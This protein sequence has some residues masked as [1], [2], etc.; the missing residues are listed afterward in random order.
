MAGRG[1]RRAYRSAPASLTAGRCATCIRPRGACA[2]CNGVRVIRQDPSAHIRRPNRALISAHVVN[3]RDCHC[4]HGRLRPVL[5]RI[6][7]RPNARPSPAQGHQRS[8]D[9]SVRSGWHAGP[10]CPFSAR[11][12]RATITR[13]VGPTVGAS[14]SRACHVARVSPGPGGTHR[15]PRLWECVASRAH[16]PCTR[17]RRSRQVADIP[18]P[19]KSDRRRLVAGWQRDAMQWIIPGSAAPLYRHA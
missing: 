1:R 4:D 3:W 7:S 11:G 8:E 10:A 5:L 19:S 14:A 13:M 16:T 17:D 12:P 9:P 2:G 18:P 15:P 6:L